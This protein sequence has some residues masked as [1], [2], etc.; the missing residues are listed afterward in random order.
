MKKNKLT[1]KSGLNHTESVDELNTRREC[2]RSQNGQTNRMHECAISRSFRMCLA[3]KHFDR[4]CEASHEET[5]KATV[6]TRITSSSMVEFFNL[7]GS[8]PIATLTLWIC[9]AAWSGWFC[10]HCNALLKFLSSVSIFGWGSL[11]S[12]SHFLWLES[13]RVVGL[14]LLPT[15]DLQSLA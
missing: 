14:I 8:R 15:K 13:E 11:R 10:H 5:V 2:K 4:R 3:L 12:F 7:C 6:I 9:F 1:H